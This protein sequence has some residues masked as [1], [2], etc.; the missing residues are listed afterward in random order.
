MEKIVFRPEGE[1]AVEFYV[2]EQT[3]LGG[4]DYIL[5]TDTE[6]EDGEALILRDTSKEGET[7][8]VYEIVTEDEELNAVAAVFENMLEDIELS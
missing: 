4:I 2:L 1:D 5:V 7:E 3:R 8:A 6:E